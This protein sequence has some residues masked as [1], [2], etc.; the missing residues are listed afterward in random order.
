MWA[1]RVFCRW[2]VPGL[3]GCVA[4]VAPSF[5]ADSPAIDLAA[6]KGKIVYLDFWASWCVPCR[7][8]FPWMNQMQRQFGKDGL[9]IVAVNMDQVR[10]DADAFLKQYP[11]EFTVRF[12]PQGGLAQTFKVRGMPTSVLL[13]RDGKPL[14]VHAG[15]RTKDVAALE[16]SIRSA[17][18]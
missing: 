18:H 1:A 16:Q 8:S 12:D 4:W 10:G 14:L 6:Y 5:A 17:L 11:A 15:F 9:V 3:L 13:G 7:Q 2:A